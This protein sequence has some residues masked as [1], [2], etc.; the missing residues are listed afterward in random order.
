M[1]FNHKLK[2]LLGH[3]HF[4]YQ[5][6]LSCIV[7]TGK[8]VIKPGEAITWEIALITFYKAGID[9]TQPKLGR[10]FPFFKYLLHC[11]FIDIQVSQVD[12]M[13]LLHLLK[14]ITFDH[15]KS[16]RHTRGTLIFY[17]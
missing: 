8:V 13:V 7:L 12:N 15:Q 5:I 2:P 3:H 6:V 14:I 1:Q 4:A 10:H 16:L 9:H 17:N 11:L